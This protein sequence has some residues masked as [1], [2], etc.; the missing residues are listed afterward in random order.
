LWKP[1][2]CRREY[3]IVSGWSAI[4]KQSTWTYSR[5]LVQLARQFGEVDQHLVVRETLPP[6]IRTGSSLAGR[7]CPNAVDPFSKCRPAPSAR[8]PGAVLGAGESSAPET[9]SRMRAWVHQGGASRGAASL[10]ETPRLV[11][12][13]C[14]SCAKR[15]QASSRYVPPAPPGPLTQI[16]RDGGVAPSSG[17]TIACDKK[18]HLPFFVDPTWWRSG[19]LRADQEIC[20]APIWRLSVDYFRIGDQPPK[21]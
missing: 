8:D 11:A 15:A 16:A 9:P 19:K 2:I 1:E 12:S 10:W 3:H 13:S 14:I 17:N 5:R 6:G 7:A 21:W 4:R 18:Y 20:V